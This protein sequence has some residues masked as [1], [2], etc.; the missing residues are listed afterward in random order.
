M[1]VAKEQTRQA[2]FNYEK[3]VLTAFKEVE[4]AL[5]D[6]D[7]YKRASQAAERKVAAAENAARLSFERYDK[8]ISSYLEVLDSERTLFSAQLES[9]ETRQLYFN[10]YVSLYKALGGGWLTSEN[11]SEDGTDGVSTATP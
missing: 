7:T 9:S 6:V 11:N 4:D 5:V 10:A 3:V 8:G 1:E 2:L